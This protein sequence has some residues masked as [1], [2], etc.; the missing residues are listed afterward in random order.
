MF[1]WIRT[2]G[3]LLVLGAGAMIAVIIAVFFIGP[4]LFDLGSPFSTETVDRTPPVVLTEIADLAEFRCHAKRVSS[5]V[6]T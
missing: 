3:K 1:D 6:R 4:N 2:G 5:S